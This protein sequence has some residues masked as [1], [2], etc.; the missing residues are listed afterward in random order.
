MKA[1]DLVRIK[2]VSRMNG[3][4]IV[5]KVLDKSAKGLLEVFYQ[6]SRL[7]YPTSMLELVSKG[8]Q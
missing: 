1:G 4:A 8:E 2:K 6:N 5:T 3:L 7:I